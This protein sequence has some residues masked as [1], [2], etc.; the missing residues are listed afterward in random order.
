M[1]FGIAVIGAVLLASTVTFGQT[2]TSDMAGLE[3]KFQDAQYALNG[4]ETAAREQELQN[5]R[6]ELGYLRVK[7][8]RGQAVTTRERRDLG[9]R[10]DRFTAQ[11][12]TAR[13]NN[14]PYRDRDDGGY[15]N[16]DN[17]SYGGRAI[18]AGTEVD[19]RLQTRLSSKDAMVEDR[20]EA[21]TLVDLYQGNDLLVP[22]G[23]LMV[24]QVTAVDKATR[25]DR[26]GS[27]TVAFNRLTVNGRTRDIRG[28][29]TQALESSGLKGEAGRVGA[30]AGVGAIIGGILG[31][32]K[33]AIAGV[34]IGGGGVLVAT[35]GKDVELD[36]GTVLRVR[37]DSM[38]PMTY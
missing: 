34:L 31:G 9:T 7:A 36:P 20:V 25:T 37:F 38:V 18:P 17:P 12:N 28:S 5:L 15:R 33:G 6:D 8:R 22:A 27:I 10:L 3:R 11:V 16:R 24:G 4:M 19:V 21:T 1:R 35:E 32:V 13:A 14:S 26:K 30:G 23:S 29:V 2:G